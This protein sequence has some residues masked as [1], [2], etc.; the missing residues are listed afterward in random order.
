MVAH[1]LLPV[2][3]LAVKVPAHSTLVSAS[4]SMPI[5]SQ[6]PPLMGG[7]LAPAPGASTLRHEWAMPS[8]SIS[9]T[10]PTGKQDIRRACNELARLREYACYVRHD[11]RVCRD[12]AKIMRSLGCDSSTNIKPRLNLSIKLRS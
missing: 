7:A 8:T 4:I 1:A 10:L 6:P 2:V 12:V 3:G 11:D 9:I 5:M